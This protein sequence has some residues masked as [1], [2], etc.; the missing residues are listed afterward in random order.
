MKEV[1]LVLLVP[2]TLAAIAAVRS[3]AGLTSAWSGL[4]DQPLCFSIQL[5]M[6]MLGVI[7]IAWTLS[8]AG[9]IVRWLVRRLY[10]LSAERLR[11]GLAAEGMIAGLLFIGLELGRTSPKSYVSPDSACRIE[12][13]RLSWIEAPFGH[14]MGSFWFVPLSITYRD[15]QGRFIVEKA[16]EYE[17][18]YPGDSAC[19]RTILWSTNGA[20]RA[21]VGFS[22]LDNWYFFPDSVEGSFSQPPDLAL[23]AYLRGEPVEVVNRMI[24][25]SQAKPNNPD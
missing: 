6:A 17:S 24:R 10:G 3:G 14:G 19:N 5:F 11:L 4:C 22:V 2:I 8:V 18:D 20:L 21:I 12:I 23:A 1:L 25:E 9:S 15:N 16:S 7:L 13:R